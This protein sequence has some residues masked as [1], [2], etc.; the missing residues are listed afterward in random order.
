MMPTYRLEMRSG[1]ATG[2][3]FPLEKAEIFVG[4]DLG[5]DIVINDPEV[6]RRHARLFLQ[7]NTYILEDLGSTNGTS[8]N[9]QRLAAPYVLRPGD[10][11]VFGEHVAFVLEIQGFDPDATVASMGSQAA[12]PP[13]VPQQPYIAPQQQAYVPPQPV[14]PPPPPPIYPNRP[15]Q[16]YAG[17]VPP[18]EVE[19]AEPRKKFPTWVV[20]V[21]VLVLLFVCICVAALWYIDSNFLWCDFFGWFFG[22]EACP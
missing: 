6:S 9:G 1:P 22:P 10:S 3:V 15:P 16:G 11:V 21:I 8:V 19:E 4:R 2:K 14:V 5:N 13:V 12:V 18:A 17:Q 20:V 7:N